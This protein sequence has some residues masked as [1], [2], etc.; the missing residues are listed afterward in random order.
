MNS[1]EVCVVGARWLEQHLE[2]SGLKIFDCIPSAVLENGTEAAR[3][4]MSAII[5][6]LDLADPYGLLSDSEGKYPFTRASTP[7][8]ANSL[9]ASSGMVISPSASTQPIK[10]SKCLANRP[11]PAGRPC[12]AGAREPV[13]TLRRSSR[14]AVEGAIPNRRA[15]ARQE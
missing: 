6:Y 5:F 10:A 13:S 15:A 1:M 8:S 11:P 9:A 2:E 3:I 4:T 14:I 7:R 12:F